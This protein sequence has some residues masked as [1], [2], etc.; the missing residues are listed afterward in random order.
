MPVYKIFILLVFNRECIERNVTPSF[1]MLLSKLSNRNTCVHPVSEGSVFLP[2]SVNC[3]Q[4]AMFRIMSALCLTDM[5]RE[6]GQPNV[7]RPGQGKEGG[8]GSQKSPNLCD[9]PLWMTIWIIDKMSNWIMAYVFVLLIEV[10][11]FESRDHVHVSLW[12]CCD[13][14]HIF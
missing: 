11:K 8:I 3:S 9:H 14:V 7:D 5:G 2:F 4:V 13:L 6:G 12:N 1:G 10:S